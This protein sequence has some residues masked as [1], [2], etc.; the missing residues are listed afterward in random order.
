MNLKVLHIINSFKAGGAELL[1]SDLAPIWYDAGITSFIVAL[2]DAKDDVG[3]A[4]RSRLE[5]AGIQFA[6][7]GK[8]R[9]KQRIRTAAEIVKL[10]KTFKPDIIHT[11]CSSPDIFGAVAAI[12]TRS[13]HICTLHN[14]VRDKSFFRK[15]V[16]RLLCMAAKTRFI[17]ISPSVGTSWQTKGNLLAKRI[18]VIPN[19]TDPRR[20]QG[21][22]NRAT[23]RMELLNAQPEQIS[24][25]AV[26]S[27]TKQKNFPCLLEAAAML[28]KQ[29]IEYH[30]TILG[31]GEE[32]PKLNDIV[33]RLE[34]SNHISMP[35]I[36]D[37]IPEAMRATD[38][39]VVPSSWEGFGL[40]A[41]EGLMAGIPVIASNVDGL[42]D[43]AMR[44]APMRVFTCNDSADLAKQIMELIHSPETMQRIGSEGKAWAIENCSLQAMAQ[45]Y[46]YFY[47]DMIASYLDMGTHK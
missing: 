9:Q 32:R 31:E 42:R 16:W 7:L 47:N 12:A 36:S 2:S 19:G 3:I 33:N 45:G 40:V 14:V 28:T 39:L 37:R 1:V 4:A 22:I 20:F 29:S 15:N 27:L 46:Q 24:I 13:K 17:A 10:V 21:D 26:G 25:L 35:G 6:I 41:T 18:T 11:H 30:L 8:K 23:V 44:G 34:L 5:A 38:I 43:L